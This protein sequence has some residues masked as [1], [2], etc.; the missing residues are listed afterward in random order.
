V[1]SVDPAAVARVRSFQRTVTRGIGA[2]DDE[3]LAR[4]RPLGHSRVLWEVSDGC[5]VRD[6]RVRLDLDSGYLSRVLRALEADGLVEVVPAPD[7]RRVRLVRLTAA[8]R[9][10]RRALD[11]RS[12]ERAAALLAALDPTRRERLVAAMEDV[13]RLVGAAGVTIEVADPEGADA[14]RCL[15]A[16]FAEIDDRFADGFDPAL[17]LPTPP[18]AMRPPHGAFLVAR[19]AGEAVGCGVVMLHEGEPAYLKRMWV[20]PTA[21]G[22]GLAHRLL[23]ELEAWAAAA[24]ATTVRLETNRALVEAIG[25]YRS[26]GYTEVPPFNDERYAHHW[27]A[28]DL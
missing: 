12:D 20:A 21:R 1:T 24:G 23:A 8:G 27:F 4:G 7:D 2:L 5:A 6:L 11:R 10:E 28:K 26:C 13:E 22:T 9:R 3:Y 18:G 17:G 15:A 25:L 16:Y 14:Q 19:R